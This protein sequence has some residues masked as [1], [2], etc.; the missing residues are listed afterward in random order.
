MTRY[1][2]SRRLLAVAIAALAGFVDASGFLAADRYFVSF[3]SGNTTRLAVDITTDAAHALVPL[4]LIG[5]FVTGVTTGAIVSDNAGRWR[6]TAVL[7]L[8][9]MLICAAALARQNSSITMMMICLVLAMGALN[10]C[11][12]QGGEVTV[13]VTYMTGSLVRIGQAIAAALQGRVLAGWAATIFLWL[14]LIGGAI[15]G[16]AAYHAAPEA[17]LGVAAMWCAA[18]TGFARWIE[19]RTAQS[20]S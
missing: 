4:G 16:A 1:D 15:A 14:G 3:M 19:S 13:G 17:A 10:N 12:R 6:K 5:G 7:A 2:R 11:F 20:E 9:A 18:L 8:S